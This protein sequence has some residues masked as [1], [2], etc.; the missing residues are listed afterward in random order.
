MTF[1]ADTRLGHVGVD[2]SELHELVDQLPDDQ[3]GVVVDAV[4][5]RLVDMSRSRTT[6]PFAWVGAGVSIGS[7]DVSAN[8]DAHLV[9]FGEDSL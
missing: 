9:G 5:D 6:R 3:V 2:R 8:L 7:S 1:T 4:R